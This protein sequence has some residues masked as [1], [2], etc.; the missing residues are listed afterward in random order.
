VGT[1]RRT[2]MRLMMGLSAGEQYNRRVPVQAGMR[3]FEFFDRIKVFAEDAYVYV[4]HRK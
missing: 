4:V 2:N 3:L 1:G